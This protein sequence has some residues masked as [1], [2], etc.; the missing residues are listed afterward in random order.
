MKCWLLSLVKAHV[1][2]VCLTD[3]Y[4][5]GHTHTRRNRP[6]QKQGSTVAPSPRPTKNRRCSTL[7][8][9]RVSVKRGTHVR[10]QPRSAHGCLGGGQQHRGVPRQGRRRAGDAETTRFRRLG[11]RQALDFGR[12]A[13]NCFGCLGFNLTCARWLKLRRQT[14]RLLGRRT[15]RLSCPTLLLSLLCPSALPHLLLRPSAIPC[16]IDSELLL[17]KVFHPQINGEAA[18]YF[19]SRCLRSSIPKSTVR[20]RATSIPRSSSSTARSSIP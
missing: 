7:A 20:R 18:S 4:Q 16:R 5:M 6:P 8:S 1:V 10:R 9:A 3:E 15:T 11:R 2:V 14:K 12:L 19:H 13:G 17:L